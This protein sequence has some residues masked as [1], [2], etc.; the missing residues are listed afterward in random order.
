MLNPD[1]DGRGWAAMQKKN[2]G[3]VVSAIFKGLLCLMEAIR[4]HLVRHIF[5]AA[6]LDQAVLPDLAV[7]LTTTE[8][9]EGDFV[10]KP[11]QSSGPVASPPLCNTNGSLRP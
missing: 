6:A 1:A 7:D 10:V 11:W 4:H 3:A 2:P 9:P 5:G 8:R